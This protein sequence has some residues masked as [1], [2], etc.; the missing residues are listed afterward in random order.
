MTIGP[1]RS[2]C[3]GQSIRLCCCV[4]P[5]S[6][7]LVPLWFF[8]HRAKIRAFH[9]LKWGRN[10]LC[11][12]HIWNIGECLF[13]LFFFFFLHYWSFIHKESKYQFPFFFKNAMKFWSLREQ[14]TLPTSASNQWQLVT[15]LVCP[16][17]ARVCIN[18]RTQKHKPWNL[19]IRESNTKFLMSVNHNPMEFSY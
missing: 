15:L 12:G 6:L 13:P 9:W 19:F 14:P 1:S 8:P 17:T 10:T 2:W 7:F 11:I 3:S 16:A 4:M 18:N 5:I